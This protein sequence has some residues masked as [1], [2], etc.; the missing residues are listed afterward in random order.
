LTKWR[1]MQMWT[2]RARCFRLPKSPVSLSSGARSGVTEVFVAT[3]SPLLVFSLPPADATSRSEAEW[4][5]RNRG[6][7]LVLSIPYTSPCQPAFCWVA[8]REK[9]TAIL[10]IRG[11]NSIGDIFTDGKAHAVPMLNG[12]CH[13]GIL[14]A[15]EWI[16]GG[17]GLVA[18][19][20][21]YCQEGYRV[22]LTGHS[23]GGAVALVCGI[24][25]SDSISNLSV[26]TYGAPG[27]C[28]L[29]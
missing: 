24:L 3:R 28:A 12:Y 16:L 13:E 17:A 26:Y 10:S 4:Q 18:V 8:S 6:F 23:L 29:A 20:G 2:K 21:R 19:I 9:K 27:P 15:A 7:E 5:A 22:I 11:S 25:L 1:P 14:T